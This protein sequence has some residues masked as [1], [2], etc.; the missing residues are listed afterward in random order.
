MIITSDDIDQWVETLGE[1]E[2][3]EILQP[4]HFADD[5]SQLAEH[6]DTQQGG[7]TAWDK[8]DEIWRV[9]P[10]ELTIWAGVNGHGKSLML[11]QFITWMLRDQKALIAS[12]EMKP[13]Q[14]LYR[15]ACQYSGCRPAPDFAREVMHKMDGR[16]WIYDQ[17][18][19]VESMRILGMVWYAAK[20]LGVDHIVVDSLMK[21]GMSEDDYNSQK[22][23]IDKLQ[24]AAKGY[25]VHIHL[26]CH[27]RKKESEHAQGGKMDIKGTGA[28]TD[29]AD[30]VFTVRRN[31]KKEHFKKLHAQ[32][33]LLSEGDLKHLEEYDAYLTLEKNRHGSEEGVVGFYFDPLS[34]QYKTRDC[35]RAMCSPF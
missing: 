31:K 6:G 32:G 9:R 17:L 16:L 26:V 1:Q 24:N 12:L 10:G 25:D 2:S 8:L 27:M 5:V 15:M 3:Q 19:T 33:K 7:L 34:M 23:F 22:R 13:Q 21:C 18:D 28:I 20:E 35:N 11:G 14:T 29:I 30:N 4:S